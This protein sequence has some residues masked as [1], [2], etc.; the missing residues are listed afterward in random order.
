[1]NGIPHEGTLKR[2]RKFSK[3]KRGTIE[4]YGKRKYRSGASAN[5]NYRTLY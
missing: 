4:K 1:M 5:S 2:G 3:T